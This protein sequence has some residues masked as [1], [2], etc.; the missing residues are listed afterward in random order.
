MD[1]SLLTSGDVAELLGV[2]RSWG[3]AQLRS[4]G[5]QTVTPGRAQRVRIQGAA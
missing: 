5:I 2:E 1:G 4:D 3:F